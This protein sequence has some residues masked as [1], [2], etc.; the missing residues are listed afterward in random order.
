MYMDFDVFPQLYRMLRNT[1]SMDPLAGANDWWEKCV[2]QF[3]AHQWVENCHMSKNTYE[4]LC[5]RLH[6]AMEKEDTALRLSVPRQKRE[7]IALWKLATDSE[8]RTVSRLFGVEQLHTHSKS[9][10][11]N[12]LR[13][14]QG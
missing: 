12:L 9:S 7:S 8:Y 5:V 10:L 6:P 14:L 2:P 13:A 3:S 4:Y 11:S 1:Q